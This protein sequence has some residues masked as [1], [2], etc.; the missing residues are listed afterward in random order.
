MLVMMGGPVAS[1]KS[2]IAAMFKELGATVVSR[3]AIRFSFLKKDEQY[4]AHERQVEREFYRTIS[5]LLE[6]KDAFV[7]ADA[8]HINPASRAKFFRRVKN[9]EEHKR[10]V[11]W[12]ENYPKK[13]KE[14]NAKRTGFAKVPE[15]VIESQYNARHSPFPYEGFD[16]VIFVSPMFYGKG[17][18]LFNSMKN[19]DIRELNLTNLAE[20]LKT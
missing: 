4:F 1:G 11:V 12:V 7:V 8:T 18:R 16:N 13:A 9:W 14:I 17:V 3:D 10:I 5:H 15:S 2:H 19:D 20:A 6:D